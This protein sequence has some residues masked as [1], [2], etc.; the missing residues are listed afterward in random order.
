[1]FIQQPGFVEIAK[2]S[3]AKTLE[4]NLDSTEKSN[5]FDERLVGKAGDVV[6]EWVENLLQT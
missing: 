5:A 2:Q 1:M 3:G 4:I 6:P